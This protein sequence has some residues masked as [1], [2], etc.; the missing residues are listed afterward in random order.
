LKTGAEGVYLAAIPDRKL[1]IA[2]KVED[3]AGRAAE[4]AMAKLLDMFGGFVDAPRA[5]IDA[6]V[7][8]ILNNY[9]G[10]RVGDIRPAPNW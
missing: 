2:L 10:L 5:E 3:G 4:V 9:A 8:P 6:L 7:N 1:G